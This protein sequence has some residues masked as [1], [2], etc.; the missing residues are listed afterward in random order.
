[1]GLALGDID[2]DK[3]IDIFVSNMGNTIP[4]RSARGDLRSD[5]TLDPEWRLIENLGNMQFRDI[6]EKSGLSGYEFAWGAIFEDWNLD[7]HLDLIVAENYIKW[8]PH[9]ITKLAG[10]FFIGGADGVFRP[11]TTESRAENYAY[12][13][14]PL[15]SD[16]NADGYPDLIITNLDGKT[17]ALL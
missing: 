7:S 3:D 2:N 15:A 11:T 13:T 1:M 9:K 17:K 12:G 5:Q 10:R 8:P 6:T 14:T 4:V 16:F